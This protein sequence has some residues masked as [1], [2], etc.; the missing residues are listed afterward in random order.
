MC[1]QAV[2]RFDMSIRETFSNLIN[3]AVVN[4]SEKA[5]VMQISTVLGTFTVSVVEGPSETEHFKHLSDHIFGVRNFE[6]T[7]SMSIIFFAKMLKISA[8]F[9]KGS[10]KLRKSCCFLRNCIWIGIVKLSLL[11]RQCFPSAAN[12]LTSTPKILHVKKRYFS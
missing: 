5:A 1:E 2:P 10:N 12:M 9:K 11:T 3:L 4:K 6:I 8:A 7:K